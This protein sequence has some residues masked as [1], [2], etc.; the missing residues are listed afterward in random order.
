MRIHVLGAGAWGTAVAI[1]AARHPARHAVTL[2]ARRDEQVSALRAEG[3]NSRYLPGV[4]FP[5][6]LQVSP[7]RDLAPNEAELTIVATPT[8]ALR[9]QLGE[10]AQL[11]HPVAW[12][13]K[14][15]EA[16]SGFMPHEVQ[17]AVA[18]QL[19]G[20]AL[21]GPSFALEVAQGKPAALV[22][23][24]AHAEVRERLVQAFHGASLRIYGNEDVV[25]A[26][27]GGAV[28]NV[29]AIAAGFS[30]GLELGMNARAA[31]LTRGLAEM[32]R[33]GQA[34][35]A[36]TD[37]FMGLSGMGDLVLTATGNLSRNRN[38]GLQLAQGRSLDA[39]LQQLGHV[40]EG[41]Y[42]CETVVARARRLG[43]EL[44]I[45]EA[46]WALLSGRL[47]AADVVGVLMGR[48]P[49]PEHPTTLP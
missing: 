1:A 29:M 45:A 18:P 35:G 32:T 16:E 19:Q 46:V 13:C 30:D 33:L 42:S 38:V 36:H 49:K 21:T 4:V 15:F 20:G 14:G 6:G 10:L 28:K 34:L 41:V 5:D 31:L 8:S 27:V 23:A 11:T 26:E 24:S 22:A 40:A 37:T 44:P 47:K 3:G 17:Q 2:F 43:V 12:L 48:E 39:I 25:G 7:W 9:G